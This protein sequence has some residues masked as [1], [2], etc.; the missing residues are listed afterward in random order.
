MVL[1]TVPPTTDHLRAMLA[2]LTTRDA[3]LRR[4]LRRARLVGKV[5]GWPLA[6]YNDRRPIVGE[7]VMLA[8][9]AA[10]LINPL[11]GEGIQ[12]ALLSAR[13]AAETAAAC[14]RSGDFGAAAL[15]GYARRVAGALNRDMA[16]ARLLVAMIR[17]RTLTPFWLWGLRAIAARSAVDDHYADV[18]GGIIAGVVPA[19]HAISR[20]VVRRTVMKGAAAI[21]ESVTAQLL[22]GPLHMAMAGARVARQ[23]AAL[24]SAV[25]RDPDGYVAWGREVMAATAHVYHQSIRSL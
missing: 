15:A 24:A 11:N 19:R 3:A 12:Y 18:V 1:E 5:V 13:W 8:G 4:R 20:E 6:T 16:V 7:R 2:E 9:D 10:G 23:G 21:E 25:A 22:R 17:N 14:A